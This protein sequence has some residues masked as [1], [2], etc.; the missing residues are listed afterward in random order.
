MN[1]IKQGCV[2]VAVGDHIPVP[3][4]AGSLSAI[5]V[6]RTIKAYKNLGKAC[7]AVADAMTK[8]PERLAPYGVDARKL[9]ELGRAAVDMDSAVTDVEA[10]AVR[11]RQAD[12]ILSSQAHDMLRRVLTF[13]RGQ[14][15]FDPR[16]GDLVP[17]LLD[18]F[19]KARNGRPQANTPQS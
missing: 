2:T 13:V 17:D 7:A 10:A 16:I 11:V 18:Y 19:S 15:K 9:A 4:E 5:E 6:R 8:N 14:Q 12:L 1:E 3:P